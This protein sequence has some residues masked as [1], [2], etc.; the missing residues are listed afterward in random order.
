MVEIEQ[1]VCYYMHTNQKVAYCFWLL[2][3]LSDNRKEVFRCNSVGY[4][5]FS[6]KEK[7]VVI[8]VLR[9]LQ[10]TGPVRS[11][12][13]FARIYPQIPGKQIS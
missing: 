3:T 6:Y 11:G 9:A 10:K 5:R 2:G 7:V 8:Q 1:K 4:K 13:L 12:F